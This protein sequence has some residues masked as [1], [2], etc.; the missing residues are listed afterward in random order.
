MRKVL[1]F[2]PLLLALLGFIRI[3]NTT[4][5]IQ[6]GKEFTAQI[7]DSTQITII[8]V[9]DTKNQL[10]LYYYSNLHVHACNTGECKLIDM[11]MYWDIFGHYFKY[12]VPKNNPLTKVNHKL[13]SKSDYVRLHIILNDTTSKLKRLSIY[14]LTEKQV[15]KNYKVD[16]VTGASIKIVDKTKIKGAI[17]TSFTLW[18]IA[19][20]GEPSHKIY[21][22][23]QTYFKQK[24]RDLLPTQ[25]T[26]EL[27][28]HVLVDSK[29]LSFTELQVTLH[30]LEEK[31][32]DVRFKYQNNLDKDKIFLFN[33]YCLR[34]RYKGCE[35]EKCIKADD[36]LN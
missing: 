20:L 30:M 13:F 18:H 31:Q 3:S 36:F 22:A 34:N 1:F 29:A 24:N 14:E 27:N 35:T 15:N 33:D 6:K 4:E 19:N 28:N 25:K 11:T 5:N 26:V 12:V 9:L 2:I 23:T 10:P 17:K 32:L 16:A 7:N 8:P 21:E